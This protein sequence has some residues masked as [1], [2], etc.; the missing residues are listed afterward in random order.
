LIEEHVGPQHTY[1][2]LEY[3]AGGSLQRHLQKL[4]AKGKKGDPLTMPESEV[5]RLAAQV[6]AGLQHLH[7]LDVAHRDLKPGNVLFYGPDMNH[8]KL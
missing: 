4:Q 2:I 5:A 6:N 7:K 8:L 3:C 1:A